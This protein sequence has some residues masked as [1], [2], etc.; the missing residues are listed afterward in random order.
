MLSSCG[1]PDRKEVVLTTDKKFPLPSWIK[2]L[3][4]EGTIG[5]GKTTFCN[6]LAQQSNSRLVLE[7]A[8]E[9][10]FL[11]KFYRERR[12][13]AFQTQLWFLTSRF[14]QLSGAIGQQ[15]LFYDITVSD[16]IFAKDRLFASVNLEE[17]ELALYG[18]ISSVMAD[19]I[20]PPDLVV[21]LQA[22][23]DTLL[24]RIERRGR[25]Y[26]FN[27]DPRYIDMLNDAYNHFFFH[28][29]E[30]PLLIIN[31]DP[32]DFVN[33][34]ADFAE[35]LD[36]IRQAGKGTTFYQPMTADDKARL[37]G[38]LFSAAAD[39]EV[40]DDTAIEEP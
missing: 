36:Q 26:E 3:C 2:Y 37:K 29:T 24:R 11:E 35:L 9:N 17:D 15:D 38:R 14:K 34:P 1:L 20:T 8:E 23:T 12:S 22:S 28:Y 33:N 40:I 18:Q 7:A 32:L 39:Q 6:L 4:I 25:P 21:Y 10:P 30:T 5:A 16:Y 19:K 27:M 13:F 31:T